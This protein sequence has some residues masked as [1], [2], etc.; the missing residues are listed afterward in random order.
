MSEEHGGFPNSATPEGS[1]YYY[2]AR[3]CAPARRDAV[4]TW[5]A[6]FELID[7]I[8]RDAR[9]PG[10]ARLK[11]D[12]W[13][14]EADYLVAGTPRHPLAQAL[15]KHLEQAPSANAMKETLA[16]A[17]RRILQ[18]GPADGN[19]F[20]TQ[21]IQ[22]WGSRF[23]LLAQAGSEPEQHLTDIA[24]HYYA[25]V[26]RLLRLRR[27]IAQGTLALPRDALREQGLVAADLET[28]AHSAALAAIAGELLEASEK[29]WLEHRSRAR[30]LQSFDP[31]VRLTAQAARNARLLK[32]NQFQS[33][34]KVLEPTPLGLLWSAW[35][36]R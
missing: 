31:V 7:T 33:H 6:W 29:S 17:E 23:R 9:D 10:V 19:E 30:R 5:L 24:G 26:A 21:C 4:A 2:V 11:L 15:A 12:W 1:A 3:F 36:Q 20:R 25:T 34:R 35:R 28:D 18:Q 22:E 8:A 13:R 14:E 16:A 27:E 32:K